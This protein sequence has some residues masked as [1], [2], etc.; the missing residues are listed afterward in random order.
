[1]NYEMVATDL[2]NLNRRNSILLQRQRILELRENL[3]LE[4]QRKID[5]ERNKVQLQYQDE[6]RCVRLG[7]MTTFVCDKC[8]MNKPK[9]L[10]RTEVEAVEPEGIPEHLHIPK[11]LIEPYD[12]KYITNAHFVC[13]CYNVICIDCVG[14]CDECNVIGC[15]K[16]M[17]RDLCNDC[18]S[19]YYN[20]APDIEDSGYWTP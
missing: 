8:R 5:N 19:R 17:N 1:M 6:I 16:C 3:R 11:Q 10:V 2:D 7:T 9:Y 20:E 4:T 12:D 18:F 14:V 13:R 15:A